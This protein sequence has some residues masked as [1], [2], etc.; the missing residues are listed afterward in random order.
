M[1]NKISFLVFV[2]VILSYLVL[3]N[4]IFAEEKK[5]AALA[6]MASLGNYDEAEKRIVFNSLQESLSK[7]YTLTSQKM[8]EIAEEEAFQVMDADECT[9]EQCIAIIQELLQVEYFFKFEIIKSG[10]FQQ[11]K[12][13][14]IDVD[15]NR[16]VRTATCDDCDISRT[17][18]KVD[19]LVKS[20]SKEFKIQE[21]KVVGIDKNNEKT[22]VLADKKGGKELIEFL[23]L[24]HWERKRCN[25]YFNT[26]NFYGAEKYL[27]FMPYGVNRITGELVEDHDEHLKLI[28]EGNLIG[29]IYKEGDDLRTMRYISSS[30]SS[31]VYLY[32]YLPSLTSNTDCYE[33]VK[34]KNVT[35]RFIKIN[36]KVLQVQ[37]SRG[38]GDHLEALSSV[39]GCTKSGR[40]TFNNLIKKNYSKIYN[41]STY[42]EIEARSTMFKVKKIINS[43]PWLK[44]NCNGYSPINLIATS[45]LE[46]LRIL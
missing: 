36:K 28:N 25:D 15:N 3:A 6:P 43:D 26:D 38:K 45:E 30:T 2:N 33:T 19:D 46:F 21:K 35:K 40:N 31:Y 14:R 20:V 9:E 4:A 8:Y 39:L 12:I 44:G 24:P 34:Q 41:I 11:M 1:S 17:N 16:D 10:N 23:Y 13:S 5:T 18:S 22:E 27:L 7:Y 42:P 29:G 37:I 32:T